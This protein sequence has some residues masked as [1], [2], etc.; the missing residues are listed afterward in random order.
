MEG[1]LSR[2]LVLTKFSELS[3]DDPFFDSLKAA[4]REFP[5]WFA[6]KADEEVYVV[7]DDDRRLSG[8]IYLKQEE[9]EVLDVNPLYRRETG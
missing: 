1:R 6:R 2:Q 7:I 8:M 3:L 4:Y 9:G 5:K